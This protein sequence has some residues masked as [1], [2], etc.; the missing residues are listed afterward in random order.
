[1]YQWSV[2]TSVRRSTGSIPAMRKHAI[3]P[4]SRKAIS[5]VTRYLRILILLQLLLVLSIFKALQLD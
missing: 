2:Y 5:S 1:M 4:L 3:P